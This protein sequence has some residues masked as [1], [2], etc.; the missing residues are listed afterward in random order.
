MIRSK[1]SW[2]ANSW[3]VTGQDARRRTAVSRIS[4]AE[5]HRVMPRGSQGSGSRSESQ[6]KPTEAA[7]A[8]RTRIRMRTSQPRF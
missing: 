7:C 3:S 5:M 2:T 4:A 1:P 6:A 8:Q